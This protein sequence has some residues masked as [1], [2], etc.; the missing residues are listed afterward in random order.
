MMI[1]KFGRA[2]FAKVS[3][4]ITVKR[5]RQNLCIRQGLPMLIIRQALGWQAGLFALSTA[6]AI[7]S[8]ILCR[9]P[10]CPLWFKPSG[11]QAA[12]YYFG[13]HR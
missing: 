2:S 8:E 9:V 13:H 10:L 12:K 3:S 6:D 4:G 7:L 11:G 5:R 1:T